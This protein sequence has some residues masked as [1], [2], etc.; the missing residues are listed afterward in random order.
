MPGIHIPGKKSYVLCQRLFTGRRRAHDG[1]M[2]ALPGRTI[3]RTFMTNFGTRLHTWLHGENVGEDEFGN[4][5]Y[6]LKGETDDRLRSA[7]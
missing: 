3:K 1:K 6:V 7:G 2:R 5:Y 4:R